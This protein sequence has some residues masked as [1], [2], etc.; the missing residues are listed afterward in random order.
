MM[1]HIANGNG[2]RK[3]DEHFDENKYESY[4]TE[5][6]GN[7]ISEEDWR[8]LPE[9]PTCYT[10]YQRATKTLEKQEGKLHKETAR[11]TN[12]REIYLRQYLE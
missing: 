7:Y 5:N 9:C 11:G 10:G 3:C 2:K 6:K 8:E 4:N 1:K 12:S